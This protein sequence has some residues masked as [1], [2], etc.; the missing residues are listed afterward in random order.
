MKYKIAAIFFFLSFSYLFSLNQFQFSIFT[1]KEI[2]K[3]TKLISYSVLSSI[4]IINKSQLDDKKYFKKKIID[5]KVVI[6]EIDLTDNNLKN[7]Q[8]KFLNES[9]EDFIL[10]SF[11]GKNTENLVFYNPNEITYPRNILDLLSLLIVHGSLDNN[12]TIKSQ[13]ETIKNRP[14]ILTCGP[15][16]SFVKSIL[17]NLNIKSRKVQT[18]TMDKWNS[19]D[20]GHTL[21]E[22]YS[23]SDQK[24]F[25][26]DIDGQHIFLK[27]GILLS[28]L[29]LSEY[30]FD[31][32]QIQPISDQFFFDYSS[33]SDF[34]VW[35]ENFQNN[36]RIWYQR[37]FQEFALYDEVTRE[38]SFMIDNKNSNDLSNN[39]KN[40]RCFKL[41]SYFGKNINCLTKVEF[42][43]KFY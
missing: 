40:S 13:M 36:P 34:F 20:N 16:V 32:I 41:K 22:I 38:Y 7:F 2:Y 4:G 43:E 9:K 42:I 27:D 23:K 30:S 5:N 10:H 1:P 26:Y 37:V 35:S 11:D 3:N 19:Y 33:F 29:E 24:W 12:K 39:D 31:D 25:L 15:A 14:I 21:L 6:E 8:I 18:M 17:D 28:L